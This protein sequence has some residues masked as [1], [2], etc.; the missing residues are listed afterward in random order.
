[1]I[2]MRYREVALDELAVLVRQE[3]KAGELAGLGNSQR[4]PGPVLPRDA[5]D[6]NAAILA[7][8]RPVEIEIALDLPE[9]GQ[10]VLPAPARGTAPLPFVI[11]GRRA[12]VGQLT[13]DRG[14]AAQHA[15]LLVLAKRRVFFV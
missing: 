2:G 15:R 11:V 4:V 7:V 5:S 9:V 12:T 13:V 8:E 6:G 3:R 10:H 1:M 14:S